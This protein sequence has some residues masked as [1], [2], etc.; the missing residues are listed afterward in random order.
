MA[1]QPCDS[2]PLLGGWLDQLLDHLKPREIGLLFN[3]NVFACLRVCHLLLEQVGMV[4]KRPFSG[5]T[6]DLS[7]DLDGSRVGAG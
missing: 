1:S 3:P 2:V 6:R 5:N 4:Q 7:A